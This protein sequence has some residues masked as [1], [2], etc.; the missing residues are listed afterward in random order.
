MAERAQCRAGTRAHVLLFA[1]QSPDLSL[2]RSGTEPSTQLSTWD[3]DEPTARTLSR[4][5]AAVHNGQFVVLFIPPAHLYHCS[6]FVRRGSCACPG[7]GTL[8]RSRTAG[9]GSASFSACEVGCGVPVLRV[10]GDLMMNLI[11]YLQNTLKLH[12]TS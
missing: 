6:G 11:W 4:L 7:A 10:P 1:Q 12:I 8:P 2:A 5:H 3:E 9:D